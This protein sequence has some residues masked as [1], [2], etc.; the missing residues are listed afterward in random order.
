MPRLPHLIR[1]A[2]D[3]AMLT[4]GQ[5]ADRLGVSQQAVARWEAGTSNPRGRHLTAMLD[6]FKHQEGFMD[7][8]DEAL[9]EE[10]GGF[11]RDRP[12]PPAPG[13]TRPRQVTESPTRILRDALA[14]LLPEYAGRVGPHLPGSPRTLDYLSDKL[15]VRVIQVR[16]APHDPR[17]ATPIRHE[18]YF[19][20]LLVAKAT[21]PQ[22]RPLCIY[23]PQ[24]GLVQTGAGAV[25]M[26]EEARLLGLEF[27][28]ATR[29]EDVAEYIRQVET[30]TLLPPIPLEIDPNIDLIE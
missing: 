6:L 26:N 10:R 7:A 12:P 11:S 15:A 9:R 2:R 16:P 30:G 28:L 14:E 22:V 19:L 3:K 25:Q 24:S 29:L 27:M 17:R 8:L 13:P 20:A 23:I 4:Q 1:E 5:L 18:I 21:N